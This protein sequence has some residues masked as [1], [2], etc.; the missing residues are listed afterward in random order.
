MMMNSYTWQMIRIATVSSNNEV[1]SLLKLDF[2]PEPYGRNVITYV[3]EAERPVFIS[4]WTYLLTE[5]RSCENVDD[6]NLN[7]E[8]DP[9]SLDESFARYIA[10]RQLKADDPILLVLML[11]PLQFEPFLTVLHVQSHIHTDSTRQTTTS[12]ASFHISSYTANNWKS[13]RHVRS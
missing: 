7:D 13:V 8:P 3:C 2:T 4:C 10:S 1:A 6:P 9:D 5:W 11:L 12:M